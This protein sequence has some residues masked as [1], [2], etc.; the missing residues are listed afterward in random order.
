MEEVRHDGAVVAVEDAGH[1]LLSGHLVHRL[2]ARVVH[3][4]VKPVEGQRGQ[5]A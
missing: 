2:L 1:R 5:G 4:A 3:Y